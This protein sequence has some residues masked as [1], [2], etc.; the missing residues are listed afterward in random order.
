MRPDG[1]WHQANVTFTDPHD[2]ERLAATRIAPVLRD[3]EDN[4]DIDSW[5]FVRKQQW[6]FRYRA[7]EHA[8][9]G[10]ILPMLTT[11]GPWSWTSSIYEPEVHAFGGPAGMDTAHALFHHDSRHVLGGTHRRSDRQELTILL[12]TAMM[13]AAELDWFEQGDIWARIVELRPPADLPGPDQWASVKTATRR[14]LTV[15][16]GPLRAWL[17]PGTR[18]RLVHRLRTG[19]RCPKELNRDGC[20]TR[21]LRAVIAH[22]AIFAWNRLGIPAPAQAAIA[23]ASKEVRPTSRRAADSTDSTAS[24]WVHAED[25]RDGIQAEGLR[26]PDPPIRPARARADGTEPPQSVIK[27]GARGV[28]ISPPE[29]RPALGAAQPSRLLS[30]TAPRPI[31]ARFALSRGHHTIV[32]GIFNAD[33]YGSDADR[34]DQRPRR[35]RLRLLPRCPRSMRP[36]AG[37]PPRRESS[38]TARPRCAAGTAALTCCRAASSRSSPPTQHWRNR[39]QA[40]GRRR[41][42]LRPLGPRQGPRPCAHETTDRVVARPPAQ[43]GRPGPS[44][45]RAGRRQG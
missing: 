13:R 36:S 15:D 23:Q 25:V 40:D 4:G 30:R 43:A 22:H 32:E 45:E 41:T 33:H 38:S 35:Q 2:A 18:R 19:R 42:G 27:V 28:A 24:Q 16:T 44:G 12:L 6:R 5:W 34:L 3:A 26:C 31:T 7:T 8:Q 20:L 1:Q 21:G 37:T 29:P 10:A 39:K 11:P 17:L 14:L 9:A